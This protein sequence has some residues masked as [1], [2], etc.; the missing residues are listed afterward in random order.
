M[1]SAQFK[2]IGRV[3]R[4]QS[5]ARLLGV[6]ANDLEPGEAFGGA[7]EGRERKLGIERGVDERKPE[8]GRARIDAARWRA[9][10]DRLQEGD[11][12][13]ERRRVAVAAAAETR[14]SAGESERRNAGPVGWERRVVLVRRRCSRWIGRRLIDRPIEEANGRAVAVDGLEL[15]RAAHQREVG[16]RGAGGVVEGK[17]GGDVGVQQR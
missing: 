2:L 9:H 4:R 10:S 13:G 8:V 14:E 3:K 15:A 16:G 1:V 6:A 17:L 12:F 11:C 7:L 5:E